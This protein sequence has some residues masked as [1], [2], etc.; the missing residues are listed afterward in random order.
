MM[1]QKQ[2]TIKKKLYKELDWL[3][4]RKD[5]IS[6]FKVEKELEMPEG[7]LKKFVDGRRGLPDNWHDPVREW[8][9]NFKK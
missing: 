3:I 7:T 2:T 9:K 6:I 5:Y 8:V 4:K 1:Q